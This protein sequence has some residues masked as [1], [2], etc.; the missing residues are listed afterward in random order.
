VDIS[1]RH[2][3]AAPAVWARAVAF[4][5]ALGLLVM[6]VVMGIASRGHDIGI[7]YQ[8]YRDVGARWLADGTY[9]LPHQL[10]G[11]YEVTLMVD[12]LYPPAAL[13]LFVPFV[14]LPAILW[15][16][17][18]LGILG[19]VVWS[20][21]PGPWALLA[22]LCLVA[23]PRTIGAVM[24][25]NTDMWVAAGVAGGLRWGWPIALVA[26]KPVFAPFLLIGIRDWR[27][28]ALGLG[29]LVVSLPMMGDYLTAMLNVQTS[30]IA[31]SIGSL[32]FALIPLVAW[33]ASE[34]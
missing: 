22:I 31:Y 20:Y 14:W 23:W 30:P 12:V 19:Y 18:P 17:I 5:T 32:P 7:D 6:V 26:L 34:R 33:H 4:G 21:R 1:A 16:A 11:P 8:F 2:T 28:W 29:L 13:P 25:G 3:K 10:A 9:Y 24:F 15:W 27:A